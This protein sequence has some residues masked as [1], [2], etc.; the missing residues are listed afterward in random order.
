MH[1]HEHH[2][3]YN[4]NNEER[5]TLSHT[6][7]TAASGVLKTLD[8]HSPNTRRFDTG[9]STVGHCGS[10]R[11]V[12]LDGR[13]KLAHCNERNKSDELDRCW[14]CNCTRSARSLNVR[15]STC[16]WCTL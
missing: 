14:R 1:K 3:K 5:L 12:V 8:I 16:N 7:A 2:E 4:R 13:T 6:H 10:A 9:I 11:L 15:W